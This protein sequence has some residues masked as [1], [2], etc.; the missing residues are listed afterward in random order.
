MR[1]A[2]GMDEMAFIEAVEAVI[3][4]VDASAKIVPL[5][6]QVYTKLS[7]V[8]TFTLGI[9]SPVEKRSEV[10]A[11]LVAFVKPWRELVTYNGWTLNIE[12][13]SA[14]AS[15]FSMVVHSLSAKLH[16]KGC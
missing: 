6:G 13:P 15:E 4:P 9:V 3:K 2:L 8:E 16:A 7:S 11:A 5:S 1:V 10:Y 14:S 12:N